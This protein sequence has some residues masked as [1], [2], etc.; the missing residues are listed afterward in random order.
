MT[1]VWKSCLPCMA[2][3]MTLSGCGGNPSEAPV[4]EYEIIEEYAHDKDAYTQG[5]IWHDGFLYEGTGR[6]G[7]SQLR[8]VDLTSGRV[9]ESRA[10]GEEYFGEGITILD[11]KIYQL[12]WEAG[13]AFV[14]D[15]ESLELTGEFEYQGEGWGLTHDGRS[16]I[17]S[18]GSAEIV[19]RDPKT[20]RVIRTIEVRDHQGTVDELNELEWVDGYIYANVWHNEQIIKIS[21]K[22]GNVVGRFYTTRL[23][24]PRPS[25]AQAVANGIAYDPEKGLFFLTG[26]LWSKLYAVKLK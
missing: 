9:V 6:V 14:Y 25:D 8:K 1:F 19:Y 21:P 16:L 18:S 5:L 2:L 12:T 7:K 24:R 3:A 17:M 10:L 20:F 15:S 26:K 11:G 13:K 4:I 22:T 23:H